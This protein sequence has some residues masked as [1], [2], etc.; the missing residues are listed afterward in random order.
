MFW[1]GQHADIS[2]RSV[3]GAALTLAT[4]GLPRD[5][6]A[7]GYYTPP[8][9]LA[10]YSWDGPLS[11]RHHRL[12]MGRGGQQSDPVRPASSAASRP[13]TTGNAARSCSAAR[14]TSSCPA[15]TTRSSPWQFSNPWF[16][17]LRGRAGVAL[18]NVLL[19]GTAGLAYG[20]LRAD[21]FNLTEIAY[22]RRLGGRRAASKSASPRV[23][24]QRP[25]GSTSTCR[26][27]LLG[28]RHLQRP[29]GQHLARG[30]QLSLLSARPACGR[31]GAA[32]RRAAGR[33]QVLPSHCHQILAFIL[34][35]FSLS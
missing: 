18:S 27:A 17:T 10:A 11:G 34:P 31:G 32:P 7:E 21:T 24:R 25:N 26:T 33:T 30:R 20:D 13:A 1:G 12:R 29:G 8:E 3:L 19:F 35:S 28:D 14:P 9:P 22:Q 23:G 15:P 6:P 4:T 16:G 5:S 2:W